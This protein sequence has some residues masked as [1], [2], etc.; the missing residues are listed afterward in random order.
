[1]LKNLGLVLSYFTANYK[2]GRNESF[3]YGLDTN[4]M[5]YDY[6]LISAYTT[7]LAKA[8]HPD[9]AKIRKLKEDDLKKMS[10]NT[11]LYSY[12]I[13]KASFIFDETVKYPSIPCYI[14]DTCTVYPIEGTCVLTGAEYI[15]ATSQKCKLIIE[16]IYHIPFFTKG[17]KDESTYKVITPF[18][19]VIN[20]IQA[21][22]R[23]FPKGSINNLIYKEIG[24]SIYG[25]TV[26]GMGNKRRF[27]IKT[28]T[29]VRVE[30]DDLTNPLIAS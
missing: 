15:L 17:K 28:E 23:E 27:D 9:Y 25:S 4:T 29:T 8:G 24:N 10:K 3:M 14:D 21:K 20:E 1:M 11:I 5:W 30:G 13:I 22:R 2:G 12:L 6:D 19:K 18:G 26:R 16:E 7:V